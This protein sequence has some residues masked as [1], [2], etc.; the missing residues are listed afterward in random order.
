MATVCGVL[1]DIEGIEVGHWTDSEARTGCTAV[2][3]PP[4]TVASGEV[5]GG[6]PATREFA[7]LDPIRMVQHVDAVVLSGGSAYGLG[8]GDGVMSWLEAHERGFETKAGRVPIVVGMSLY[9]LGVGDATVRPGAT[10]GTTAATAAGS[11]PF[12]VGLVGA[13]TGATMAKWSRP[14]TPVPGGLVT[15]TLAVGELRVS[16]LVVVNAV[17]TIDDGTSTG[18]PGPPPAPYADGGERENTT[19]GIVATNAQLDKLE[20]HLMAQS[21]HDGLARALLPAHTAGDG[22]AFVACATGLL[23]ADVSHVR[24]LA[25]QAVVRAVRSL[26]A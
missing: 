3:L 11:G 16:A 17:G 10:E 18:D 6:A 25:Q 23:E 20:C 13:G 5:R 9:D 15:A 22:D 2:L 24:V 26:A 4:L 12:E 7:L 14:E 21:A 1:T 19:I 8:T